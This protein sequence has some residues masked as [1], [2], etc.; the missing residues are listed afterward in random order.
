MRHTGK[1]LIRQQP[2][3]KKNIVD[4]FNVEKEEDQIYDNG[5]KILSLY[6]FLCFYLIQNHHENEMKWN[7]NL[8]STVSDKYEVLQADLA[9]KK[10]KKTGSQH[11]IMFTI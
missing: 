9:Q 7:E 4:I 11:L 6:Y 1:W 10:I 3:K 2:E 8:P 5:R